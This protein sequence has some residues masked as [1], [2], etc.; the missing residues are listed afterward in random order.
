MQQTEQEEG[1]RKLFKFILVIPRG[2]RGERMEEERVCDSV[3][4][5]I[6]EDCKGRQEEQKLNNNGY[7]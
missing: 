1:E 7:Y 5:V 3:R 6:A 4:C 2:Q